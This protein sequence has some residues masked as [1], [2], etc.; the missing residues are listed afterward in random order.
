MKVVTSL[1]SFNITL[2]DILYVIMG[3]FLSA[4]AVVW[5]VKPGAL[6]PAG[7]SGVTMLILMGFESQFALQLSY[8]L[9]Y[10][11][12]NLILLSFVIRKL[13]RKFL[14]LSFI[15]VFLTSTLI[16]VLPFVKVTQDIVL[17]AIFGGILNGLGSTIT[18]RA[19]GSTGGT[20]F[21]A[22]YYSMVKNKPQWDKI[23]F[24]NGA[25]LI[26]SGWT[27]NWD[28][29]FYSIIYQF[30]STKIIDTFHNRYKLSR[31]QVVTKNADKVS[32][33]MLEVTRHGITKT[34]AMGMF[35]QSDT[36]LLYMVASDFEVERI[37]NAIKQSD[38]K[39]FIEI[40]T[41]ERVEGNYRQKPLD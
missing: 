23:M 40:S 30:V 31:I 39:A 21:I 38:S 3:S 19:N 28:M 18:L 2:K 5:F 11:V 12:L 15:H 10:L 36:N 22:I 33:A 35:R 34:H 29:A 41:V 25:L 14:L 4:S 26:Y 16:S 37:V 32:A 13:G 27:Y 6:I 7:M 24:F 9:V 17:V 8:G 1:K 20:D